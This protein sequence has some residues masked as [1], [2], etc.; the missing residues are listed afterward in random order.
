METTLL[1]CRLSYEFKRP[2]APDAPVVLFLHG[3]GCDGSIFSFAM[4]QLAEGA[5][6]LTLDFPGHGKSADPPTPWGVQEYADMVLALLQEQNIA[7]VQVVAHSFGARVAILLASQHPEM[8]EKLIITGGAGIKK[9]DTNAKNKRTQ[10]YKRYNKFLEKL[11]RIPGL[12][13]T[14]E[15]AQTK[16]R[17]H[18]GSPDYVKLNEG[19]RKTFVKVISLDLSPMLADIQAPTLLVWGGNDTETPLWM[20]QEMEKS[21][22]D[23]GMV[24]FE[25]CG[26]YAFL[27]EAQRFAIIIKQFLLEG[28][29]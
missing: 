21:I 15:I 17:N 16:L 14:V 20:G 22:P 12:K 23:V 13:H 18:Y 29:G 9:P 11:K 26:H 6:I 19:M 8:I 24:V 2:T 28:K 4:D 7:S 10:Q 27:E 25:G 5:A 3:W 1:G